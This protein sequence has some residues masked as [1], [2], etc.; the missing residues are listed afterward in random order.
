MNIPTE[1][2][3][4]GSVGLVL[5]AILTPTLLRAWR[6]RRWRSAAAT[7]LESWLDDGGGDPRNRRARFCVRYRYTVAGFVHIGERLA[8]ASPIYRD[9]ISAQR[10]QDKLPPGKRIEVWYDPA[11]PAEVVI[12]KKI[13]RTRFYAAAL[14]IVCVGEALVTMIVV[15][16]VG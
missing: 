15:L 2:V 6:L 8:F 4:I 12:D 9:A 11:N 3:L 1:T 7:V 5:L 10:V 16:L 14:G 13:S